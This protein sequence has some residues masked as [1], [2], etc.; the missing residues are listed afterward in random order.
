MFIEICKTPEIFTRD[1]ET[2]PGCEADVSTVSNALRAASGE[3]GLRTW[4]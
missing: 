4:I 3:S 1:I 2:L